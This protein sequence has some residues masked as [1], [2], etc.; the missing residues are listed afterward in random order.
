[1]QTSQVPEERL[2]VDRLSASI[3]ETARLTG[4]SPWQVYQHLRLGNY[5]A[6]KSGRRTLVIWSSV[7]AY[8]ATLP[9]F[10]ADRHQPR[11]VAGRFGKLTA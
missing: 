3:G 10:R 1:M 5:H 11:A 2:G 4:E 9:D 8:Q 7:I 6:I